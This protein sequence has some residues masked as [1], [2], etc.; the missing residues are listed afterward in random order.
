MAPGSGSRPDRRRNYLR[1]DKAD[2]ERWRQI[3]QPP[4]ATETGTAD[5]DPSPAGFDSWEAWVAQWWPTS[6]PGYGRPVMTPRCLLGGVIV[7]SGAG[8]ARTSRLVRGGIPNGIRTRAAGL[9]V[10]RVL[11][12][13]PMLSLKSRPT[14]AGFSFVPV[15]TCRDL[16]AFVHRVPAG[17]PPR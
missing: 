10:S 15:N 1:D 11:A 17:C 9:K 4:D 14:R 13:V 12:S 2:L 3:F 6:L 5:L 7:A 8:R 16:G